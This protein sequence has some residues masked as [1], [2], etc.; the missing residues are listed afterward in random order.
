VGEAEATT[1]TVLPPFGELLKRYRLTAGLTQEALAERAG[2]SARA[3]SDLERDAARL[4]RLDSLALLADALAL[5]DAE[6]ATLRAAARPVVFERESA[7]ASSR[8]TAALPV[9]LS[10]LVGR[11]REL[12]ELAALLDPSRRLVTL[13]GPAGSGKTRLAL[14]AARRLA[15]SFADGVRLVELGAVADGSLVPATV[16]A[17]L[18]VVEHHAERVAGTLVRRL[19]RRR[20]L[21]VLDNCEHVVEACARLC[22]DLLGACPGLHVLVTSREA[23]GLPGEHA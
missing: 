22:A 18:G 8:P 19:S 17:A 7:S 13:T 15:D 10:S 4:P 1:T 23:F 2:L 6:R 3:V 20:L 21:L 11:E 16:A 5:T 14:K 12:H 9:P